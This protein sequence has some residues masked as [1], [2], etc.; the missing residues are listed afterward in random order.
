MNQNVNSLILL[1]NFYRIFG[2][3]DFLK[4]TVFIRDPEIIKQI[5]IK[6]FE[7]FEDHPPFIDAEAT[8]DL[9]GKSLLLLTGQKWRDM[10]I[11]LSPAFAGSKMRIMFKLV[12]KCVDEMAKHLVKATSNGERLNW[13]MK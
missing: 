10:R 11:T 1:F 5:T 4:P 8:S 9:F 7:H 13:E 6:D 2:Y 3:Y 12:T